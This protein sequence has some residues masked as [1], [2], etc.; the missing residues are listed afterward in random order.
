MQGTTRRILE[1]IRDLREKVS[2]L[3]HAN[4]R[5]TLHEEEPSSGGAS[6][7]R[8]EKLEELVIQLQK[9]IEALEK[10]A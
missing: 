4:E 6:P 8:T 5:R 1:E 7:S 3:E 2:S 10:G 9:R